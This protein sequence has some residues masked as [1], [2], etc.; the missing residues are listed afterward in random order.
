MSRL[1]KDLNK[2]NGSNFAKNKWIYLAG[3]LFLTILIY[4]NSIKNDFIYQL[5]DDVYITNCNDIKA[6]S[7]ANFDAIFSTAYAGLYLPLTMLTYMIEFHFF[8]LNPTAYHTVN[9]LLHLINIVLVFLL[10][11]KIKPKPLIAGFVALFF[12]IHPMHAEAVS[13]LSERKDLLFSMF[14]LIGLN[15]YVLYAREKQPKFFLIT[16]VVFILSLLSKPLAISFPLFLVMI[17]WYF[18]R[19]FTLSVVT[20]KVPFFALSLFFG[21]TAIY[22]AKTLNPQDSIT[23]VFSLFNRIFIVSDAILF[24]LYKVFAPL[25]LSV[26][27]YYPKTVNGLI[28]AGFY[29]S[30]VLL[31]AIA[32]FVLWLLVYKLKNSRR[33]IIFG[34]A[35]FVIPTA[36]VLQLVPV[37]RAYAA[38]RYTYLSYIG[39]FFIVAFFADQFLSNKSAFSAKIKP[40]LTG[41][42]ILVTIVFSTL[43]W[44]RNKDWK[45]SL[46]MFTD[47]IEKN[48]EHG[49]PYLARGITKFQFGDNKGA[50]EDY[51]LCIK[52]D[53]TDS[54]AYSNRASVRGIFQDY[55]GA[56]DDCNKALQI[57]P[58]YINALNNRAAAKLYLNDLNG[59]YED[60]SAAI[61]ID[62]LNTKSYRN[63][64][65]ISEKLG[66]NK[67][68]LADFTKLLQFEPSNPANYA[69]RGN[70]YYKT[71]NFE[72]AIEDFTNALQ[73]NASLYAVYFDR[74]NAYFNIANYDLAVK[75]FTKVIDNEKNKAPAYFNRGICYLKLNQIENACSDWTQAMNLGNQDAINQINR[76]CK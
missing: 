21:L 48:P 39:I 19:K 2:S 46:T 67:N 75:D 44:E 47:L 74:G 45:D 73:L 38:E 12:A 59:A 72:L 7:S 37:G 49:H 8:G 15:T 18:G 35:F 9:L 16:L 26:Y 56:L 25:N 52:Y 1:K 13:W 31:L 51:N 69:N 17:D 53:S 27:H 20:E 76:Y 55:Q 34:L 28:P 60:Y 5:D 58:G 40:W 65:A 3:I 29:F 68:L 10:I 22:F 42:F 54:K 36:F 57:E 32:L 43:T 66:N 64:I 33:D 61:R 70:V 30:A 4:S 41:L 14:Y 50:L 62:S 6:F 63:R 71:K 24:Y 11:F 23:P